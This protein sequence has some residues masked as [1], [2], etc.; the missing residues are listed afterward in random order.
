LSGKGWREQ[1]ITRQPSRA[2]RITVAWPIPRD[3]PVRSSVLVSLI[4]ASAILAPS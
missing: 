4:R 1:V 2:K 3:A